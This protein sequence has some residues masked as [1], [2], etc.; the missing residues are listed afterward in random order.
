[1]SSLRKLES[2]R[3]NGAKSRGPVTPEGK[4][5]S[6]MNGLRH[7]FAAHKIV[8]ATEDRPQFDAMREAFIEKHHPADDVESSLVDEMV[9]ANWR[10]HRIWAGEAALFD[11]QIQALLPNPEPP[12]QP[13][14]PEMLYGQA[15]EKLSGN[16]NALKLIMRYEANCRWQ[17]DRALRNLLSLRKAAKEQAYDGPMIGPETEVKFFYCAREKGGECTEGD[18]HKLC[19][20][21]NPTAAIAIGEK[22]HVPQQPTEPNPTN[23]HRKKTSKTT[24]DIQQELGHTTPVDIQKEL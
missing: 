20:R 13:A 1:M 15:F 21:T 12:P 11:R 6:A 17:Y 18:T 24:V 19:P 2:A 10:L 16:E 23:E 5:R 8:L 7:G 14:N 4:D 22:P 3:T 9:V